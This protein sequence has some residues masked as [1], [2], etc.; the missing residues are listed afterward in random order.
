MLLLL[1]KATLSNICVVLKYEYA[2]FEKN[3]VV[4]IKTNSYIFEIPLTFP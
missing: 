3:K 1:C 4:L 2:M